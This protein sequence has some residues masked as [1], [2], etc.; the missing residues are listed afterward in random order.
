M[1]I[2]MISKRQ[3]NKLKKF[4]QSPGTINF[5]MNA[6]SSAAVFGSFVRMHCGA[7][8]LKSMANL[9][10]CERSSAAGARRGYSARFFHHF[11]LSV[12]NAILP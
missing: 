7:K 9:T 5:L 1:K 10:Q 2:P 6:S 11:P 12:E 8:Y 3:F 4:F